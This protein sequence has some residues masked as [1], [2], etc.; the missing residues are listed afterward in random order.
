ME[1]LLVKS[2]SWSVVSGESVKPEAT[3]EDASAAATA[4]AA[5][6]RTA[7]ERTDRTAKSDIILAISPSELKLIKG[8]E[9]SHAL[10]QRLQATYQSAGPARKA[11]LLKKLTLHRMTDGEEIRDHLRGFFDT[12]DKLGEMEVE[13][14]PDL[15]TIMLLYSL[16]PAF[17]NFRCF[18]CKRFGH[19]AIECGKSRGND[20]APRKVEDLSMYASSDF[21]PPQNAFEIESAPE[22]EKWCLDSG[23]SSHLC[24]DT[25]DFSEISN[26]A[27]GT[28]NLATK[29]STEIKARGTVLFTGDV[30]GITKRVS[31]KDT[32]HVPELRTNLL[33]V[34]KI[35]DRGYKVIF[36]KFA[37][38]IVDKRNRQTVLFADRKDGL[39]YI[40]E[41]K[42]VLNRDPKK[43]K[44]DNRSKKGIFLGYS[45]V[46]KGYRVWISG[47]RRVDV[48]RDVKFLDF[49]ED[50]IADK[51]ED[52]YDDKR[53]TTNENELG[54]EIELCPDE[55]KIDIREG[56]ALSEEEEEIDNPGENRPGRGPG[57][58]RIVRT[59][60]R[61]RPKKSLCYCIICDKSNIVV[62]NIQNTKFS[63][64]IDET[65]EICNEKWMIFQVRY[66]DPDSG[67]LD[68]H[69]QLVVLININAKNSSTEKL[70]N[71]LRKEMY[72]L[73]VPFSNI[74]ALSCDKS[75]CCH[76]IKASVVMLGKHVSFNSLK[77]ER[78]LKDLL[79][80]MNN[81]ETKAYFL[82]LDYVLNFLNQFNVYFQT[83]QTRMHVLHSKCLQFL[84]NICQNFLKAEHL[85]IFSK[86]TTENL[87]ENNNIDEIN[88]GYECF[89]E[90][91]KKKWTALPLDCIFKPAL[92]ERGKTCLGMVI[93]KKH[94]SLMSTEN[95]YASAAK[96]D[97]STLRLYAADVND[98]AGPLWTD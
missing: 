66:L 44:F 48:S 86:N 37:A 43:G 35:T 22:R 51:F 90:A 47:E 30:N 9:T 77:I 62:D 74:I 55:A 21:S 40:R 10:W 84:Y 67:T 70:F 24:R 85:K 81:V 63:R 29:A 33:S 78:L 54:I 34:G 14:N 42:Y 79:S 32:L 60:L 75:I 92:N 17:E 58:P 73:Q 4:A 97:K 56:D 83:S 6:A 98:I 68:I 64:F 27:N 76:A 49:S 89:D 53:Q 5:A 13:I 12:V 25:R 19:K 88:L 93:D 38:E 45:D 72:K 61:G 87:D 71:A 36:D 96:K 41:S 16:P 39:Y 46:S 2:D 57:R 69:T 82:F 28:L 3:A 20:E 23:C 59:G 11:S 91:L 26:V 15:L 7:W 94:L 80:I 1:A 18:R 52:F 95:L 50:A 31:V 8:C 65:S